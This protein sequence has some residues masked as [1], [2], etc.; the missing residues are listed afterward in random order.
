[1]PLTRILAGALGHRPL[2]LEADGLA[3]APA[4]DLLLDR[5]QQVVGLVLLDR[6]VGVARDPEQVRLDDL[7]APEQLVEV[8]LDHLVE[9]H[10]LVPLDREQARQAGRDLDAGEAGLAALRVAQ[11]DRDRQRQRA[12]VRERVPGIHGKRRE[13]REDLVV[14]PAP[15][16]LVVVRDLVVV[17]DLHALGRE[18]VVDARP[19]R[20]VVRDEPADAATDRVELL[21]G[22]HPVRG[23]RRRAC[24]DLAPEAGHADLEELVEVVGE[25]REELDPLEQWG[26]AVA[27]LVEHAGVELDPRQLA[28][29][30]RGTLVTR[31]APSPAA[32]ARSGGGANGDHRSSRHAAREPVRRRHGRSRTRSRSGW[33]SIPRGR[34]GHSHPG[35]GV[36]PSRV[37]PRPVS[38][39]GDVPP[40]TRPGVHEHA[41]QARPSSGPRTAPRWAGSGLRTAHLA[42]AGPVPVAGALR[43]ERAVAG[44]FQETPASSRAPGTN[45]NS[46]PNRSP[47]DAR[48]RGDRDPGDHQHHAEPAEE[49]PGERD[50]HGYSPGCGAPASGA[51]TTAV[52]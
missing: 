41:H 17:E 4:P 9:Q 28:V 39:L 48:D 37:R 34:I 3:E 52:P 25:D 30:D 29:E 20:R 42:A 5:E 12:D 51:M 43:V 23:V 45:R 47:P 49:A 33:T 8:R 2:D 10:E 27:C 11:A 7:H 13:H 32:D 16:R 6:D 36:D 15:Q 22:G 14:E 40:L 19:D 26:P 35:P 18:L 21:G 1:M 31:D 24:L 46:A 44:P 50:A 38:A